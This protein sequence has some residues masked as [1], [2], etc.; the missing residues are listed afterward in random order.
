LTGTP[1]ARLRKKE[2]W[3][4]HTQ[5]LMSGESLTKAAKRCGVAFTTGFRW[6]HRF[7]SAPALDK[8]S[9]L[10]GIV[11]V[12]ETFI[13]ESFKGKRSNLPRSCP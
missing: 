12:D 9:R 2:R 10:N 8:P 3:A 13:L 1:L 7:L 11:E 6:R 4:D 5:A